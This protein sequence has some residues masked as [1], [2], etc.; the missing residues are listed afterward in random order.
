MLYVATNRVS[1]VVI[2]LIAAAIGFWYL[3][4]HIP[5]IHAR[6][7]TWLHPLNP[8]LYNAPLGSYQVAN[9]TFAQAAGGLFG[10]GF[11]RAALTL[12]SGGLLLP[13]PQ[14]DMIYAVITDELGLF[15]AVAVLITYLLFVARGFKTALLARDS[16]S[17]S[18]GHRTQRDVRAAGVRDRGRRHARDPPD[19]RD[20]AVH[21]LRRLL[22]RGQPRAGGAPA[23]GLGPRAETR[24]SS[25]IVRLFAFAVAPFA[26]LVVFT[27]RWTVF[28]AS[29]STTNPLNVCTLLDQLQ[30][31]RGD[32]PTTARPCWPVRCRPPSTPGAAS[33]R[34]A[35]CYK[36]RAGNEPSRI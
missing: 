9:S 33:I 28:Q 20:A 21:L 8:R 18:A 19:R 34:P 15:G 24:V 13:A 27:S 5:H 26:L 12:P 11:G 7:E 14:T 22:N 23:A 6:V 29:S 16:F 2:G 35:T 25:P 1:F 17:D 31:K 32:R 30:I 3:G 36:V 4:T 10:Q